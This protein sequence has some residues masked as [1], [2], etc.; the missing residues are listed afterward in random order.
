MNPRARFGPQ[1]RSP[2]PK[3]V[4]SEKN[5]K[6]QTSK[7]VDDLAHVFGVGNNEINN[8]WHTTRHEAH[9][10]IGKRKSNHESEIN[11]NGENDLCDVWIHAV[12]SMRR[13]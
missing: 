9:P 11:Q 10:L 7:G 8:H 2:Q 4:D 5:R 12:L 1:Q 3:N 13:T 6:N